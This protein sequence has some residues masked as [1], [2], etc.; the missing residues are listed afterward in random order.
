MIGRAVWT[1]FG[2]HHIAA[3]T[4]LSR[5]GG[6]RGDRLRS[7]PTSRAIGRERSSVVRPGND[8]REQG[9]LAVIGAHLG[10]KVVLHDDQSEPGMYDLRAELGGGRFAAIEVTAAEDERRAADFG[11]LAG[12]RGFVRAPQLKFGWVVYLYEGARISEVRRQAPALLV[13]IERI[14]AT[15]LTASRGWLDDGELEDLR[16][17]FAGCG[18]DAVHQHLWVDPGV[19]RMV[20]PAYATWLSMDPDD[21]VTFVESF[22]ES[23]PSD[24]AK[25]GRSNADERHIF[26]W[27]G[28]FSTA[29]REL[30]ALALDVS[31]LPTRAPQLPLEVT[32]VWV[33]GETARPSRI[34]HWSPT[35]GWVEVA[36]VS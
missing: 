29:E 15:E 32:H 36:R 19:I 6:G 27:S 28:V 2:V 1:M 20:G 10:V 12:G 31:Q 13:E 26:I 25:L 21:V 30:R 34:V 5:P 17:R 4:G 35:L 33:A 18:V 24:V 3:L 14:G 22:V 7:L 8:Y 23:R 9:A 11:A 16:E